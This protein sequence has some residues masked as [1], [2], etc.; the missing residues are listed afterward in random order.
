[1][2]SKITYLGLLAVLLSA[3]ITGSYVTSSYTDDI[4]FNPGDVPP[5]IVVETK[6]VTIPVQQKS[7]SKIIVSEISETEEGANVMN[8]Y[9]FDG[10]EN[11]NYVVD[12]GSTGSDTLTYYE[13]G[14]LQYVINN[15]YDDDGN[16]D[17]AYRIN[18]FHNPYFYD[19]FY[20]DSWYYTPYYYGGW[21]LSMSFGWDWGYPYYGYGYGYRIMD[22]DTRDM[23]GA[24]IH[25][26][27][28]EDIIHQFM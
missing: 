15:Y 6:T 17:Y 2:K 3:C 8:N 9:V 24:I 27:M 14:E 23:D 7:D 13:D 16:V 18:Q 25:P 22:G 4:Y 28:V 1:M 26:I 11:D 20:W 19:P 12:Q 10:V 21:G 5:P